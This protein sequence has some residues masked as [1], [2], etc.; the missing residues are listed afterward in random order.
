MYHKL[1][2]LSATTA[3]RQACVVYMVGQKSEPL[4]FLNELS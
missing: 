4:V 1:F 3:C 2:M